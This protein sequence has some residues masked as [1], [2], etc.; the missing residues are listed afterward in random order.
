M[1]ADKRDSKWFVWLLF[2]LFL[3]LKL[4]Q[5]GYVA[6]WNWIWVCSPM[7]INILIDILVYMFMAWIKGK[8]K[9]D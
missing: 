8:E 4:G 3:G 6:T 9:D 7:W 2:L 1:T 5:F